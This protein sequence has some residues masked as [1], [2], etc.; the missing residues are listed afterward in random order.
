MAALIPPR[1]Q[2]GAALIVMILVFAL[3]AVLSASVI[4]RQQTFRI[5]TGNLLHWDQR[6]QVAIGAEA[7][8]MQALLDDLEDDQ[9]TGQMLDDCAHEQWAVT[10][11]PT[12]YEGMLIS[13]TVQDLQARFNLNSLVKSAD[14]GLVQDP[15]AVEA[16][17]RLLLELMPEGREQ[18]TLAHEMADWIDS[19]FLVDGVQ[20][21]EDGEYRYQR[22]PNLPIAHESEFRAVR[23]FSPEMVTVP[24]FWGYLTALPLGALLNINTAPAPVL[25]AWLAEELGADVGDWILEARSEKAFESAEQFLGDTRFAELDVEQREALTERLTVRSDFFQ[26]MIDVQQE[27]ASLRLVSRIQRRESGAAA[28]ISRQVVPRL[29]P[30]EP[31]CNPLYNPQQTTGNETGN[32]DL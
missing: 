16:L 10:I 23:S 6:Y 19:N 13:A 24:H 22:V 32:P 21:A 11:P 26:V 7:L 5:K 15:K 31:P 4:E 2:R 29:G 25:N 17:T 20:G 9:N 27:D 8:A 3:V 28:V 12:P 30:L 14:E 18:Q 1:L